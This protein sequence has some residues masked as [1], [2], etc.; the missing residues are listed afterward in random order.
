MSD[1]RLHPDWREVDGHHLERTWTFPDFA[2]ALAF[3]NRAAAVCEEQNHHA[4]FTLAWGRVVVR[5]WSHDVD[6]I[7]G[8]DRKLAA[9]LDRLPV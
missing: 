5:T 9:A 7:T 4:E 6:G 2:S 1:A 3:L 8:R